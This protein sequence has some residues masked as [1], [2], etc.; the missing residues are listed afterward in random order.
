MIGLLILDM[1]TALL[2]AA[3]GAGLAAVG[4]GIGI[5]IIG[6]NAMTAIAR[7]PDVGGLVG[8]DAHQQRAPPRAKQERGPL[9]R[10]RERTK[11]VLIDPP[12]A[13]VHCT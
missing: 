4:A 5:G 9:H 10:Q 6:G 7:P 3:V 2:G 11:A 1:S 13:R 8:V 12:R